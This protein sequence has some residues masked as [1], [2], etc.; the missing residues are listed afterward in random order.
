MAMAAKMQLA[1]A[2]GTASLCHGKQT[3]GMQGER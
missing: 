2:F 1:T 3:W